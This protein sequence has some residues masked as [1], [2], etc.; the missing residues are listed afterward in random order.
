MRNINRADV[1]S[2]FHWGTAIGRLGA[3]LTLALTFLASC[4]ARG[5]QIEPPR[6]ADAEVSHLADLAR[7]EFESRM[8]PRAIE[9]TLPQ[10]AARDATPSR[11][12]SR[13]AVTW[14]LWMLWWK[15]RDLP[16]PHTALERR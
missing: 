14:K 4:S 11:E 1:R 9:L 10:I 15:K 7:A 5:G 2:P 6:T 13:S 12:T 16:K 3:T 8:N